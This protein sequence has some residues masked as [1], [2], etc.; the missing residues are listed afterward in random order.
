MDSFSFNTNPLASESPADGGRRSSGGGG[1]SVNGGGPSSSHHTPG[2]E[3]LKSIGTAEQIEP[4]KR[5]FKC[6]IR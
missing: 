5:V 6:M 2:M 3:G 1:G 4:M